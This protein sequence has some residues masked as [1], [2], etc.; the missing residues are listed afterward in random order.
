MS[1]S[2]YVKLARAYNAR[3]ACLVKEILNIW[4]HGSTIA[5]ISVEF[6]AADFVLGTL[7]VM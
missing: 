6:C 3:T 1:E 7:E 2:D 5:P 4:E